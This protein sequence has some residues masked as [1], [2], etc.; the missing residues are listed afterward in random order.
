VPGEEILIDYGFEY[1][2]FFYQ[3]CHHSLSPSFP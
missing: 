3:N 2:L 1:W